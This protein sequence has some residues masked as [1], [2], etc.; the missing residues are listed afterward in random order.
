M[1]TTTAPAK[2]GR[3]SKNL[4]DLSVTH[5]DVVIIGSGYGGSIAASRL[6]AVG[7]SVCLL[8]RGR[9]IL[10]G[11]YPADISGAQKEIELITARKGHLKPD[12]NGMMQLRV[13][14]DVNVVLGNGL[15]GGSLVNAGVSIEPDPR[16]FLEGWP[17][18]YQPDAPLGEATPHPFRLADYYTRVRTNLGATKLP[19]KITL[20]KL[21]ALEKSAKEMKQNFER[22][23]INVTFEDGPNHFGFEQKACNM[24]G[25]C[26]SGCNYEAKNTLL[27]NYLPDAARSGAVLVTEAE[28]HTV[29]PDGSNWTISTLDRSKPVA[30][31]DPIALSAGM[32]VLAAGSL[33]STEILSRSVA[34]NK[35]FAVSSALGSKFSM[36]GDVLAFGFGANLPGSNGSKDAATPLYSIG[37][38]KHPPNEPKYQSGPCITGVVRVDME[39]SK[40][41]KHGL[42]IEDGTAPGLFASAY[43]PMMFLQEVLGGNCF[44]YPDTAARLQGLADLGEGIQFGGDPA[45][46]SYEG[47]MAQMQCYLIMSHDTAHG[48]LV[49]SPETE[50]V[51]VDWPKA[52]YAPVYQRD[53]DA[54]E[55]ASRAIWANLIPNPIWEEGFGRKLVSVHPLG[56]CPMADSDAE[57]VTDPDC[58][59]YKGDGQ[60]SVYENFLICDGSVSPTSLGVNPLLTI[61]AITER[62]MDKL[63]GTPK[64]VSERAKP[65]PFPPP[66]TPAPTN[67]YAKGVANTGWNVDKIIS[68]LDKTR[69]AI[70]AIWVSAVGNLGFEKRI[71]R[72]EIEQLFERILPGADLTDFIHDFVEACDLPKDLKP[73]LDYLTDQLHKLSDALS[74]NQEHPV[75]PFLKALFEVAGDI[76]PGLSFDEAMRGYLS[77]KWDPQGYGVSNPYEIAEASGKAMGQ[78]LVGEFTITAKQTLGHDRAGDITGQLVGADLDGRVLLNGAADK[79]TVFHVVDGRFDLLL[80]DPDRVETWLMTYKCK[81]QA[82]GAQAATWNMVGTKVLRRDPGSFWWKDL[83]TLYVDLTPIDPAQA[84]TPKQGIIRLDLQDLAAQLGTVTA[85]FDCDLT[86]D[87]LKNDLLSAAKNGTLAKEITDGSILHKAFK[88]LLSSHRADKPDTWPHSLAFAL[89]EFFAVGI[90]GTFGNLILRTY[91][92][93]ISYMQDFPSESDGTLKA[94]PEPGVDKVHG[95]LCEDITLDNPTNGKIR[96]FHFAP[97]D[98]DTA[99]GP[100]LLAPGMS[101]T[102]LSFALKTIDTSL[103]ERLLA[104]NYDVWLFDSRLSPTVTPVE[105]GYTLDDVASQDWPTAVDYVLANTKVK[106]PGRATV[107]ILGHCVGA[108]T[109]Q[110][111]L[112]GGHVDTAKVRQMIVMQ[113]TVHPAASAFDVIKSE[114]GLAKD[115]SGGFPPVLASAVHS[116]MGDGAE[117]D[118]VKKVLE[119][120]LPTIDPVS[121][122]P[123]SDAYQKPLDEIHNTVDWS[124]PF[125]IDHVCYSPTCHRIYGL[126]GPVIAHKNLNE[127]T[128]NAM[129]QMFG[130]IATKP[131]VQLGLIMELGRAVSAEGEDIYLPNYERLDMPFHVISGSLN[132]IVQPE[133]GFRTIQ[134]L[135]NA[136]PEKAHQFTRTLVKGYAHNDCFIGKESNKDVFDGIMNVLR[137]FG[138]D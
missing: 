67:T 7:K 133:S 4:S 74:D 117:W 73:G 31:Q 47:I 42:L 109:A 92:G 107:Q 134:W 78:S 85:K 36:N 100:I 68:G 14:D 80:P 52:G 125:G 118:A 39:M 64:P 71:V 1:T 51:S 49:Y 26:C 50:L 114:V 41:L 99:K 30:G 54:L 87:Q 44:E 66:S 61:S 131:F 40:P 48:K 105:S 25:D 20:P 2:I 32:V 9:E 19:E 75:Q 135:K 55:E 17:K 16:V 89:E 53:N 102:A 116:M 106:G 108:L 59:L 113:F 95:S 46:L 103:V 115:F 132:Q 84:E 127:A 65:T 28:V 88:V 57:G 110:M 96:L 129:R 24:C 33:G 112:L 35:D 5:F 34:A 94:L 90:G 72:W 124:A 98:P 128:H 138:G 137:P 27:M 126:Y 18:A 86:D 136:M 69:Y 38:G 79:E 81:L 60:N 122:N 97:S 23:D 13:N 130:E 63:V 91:G 119:D 62:A 21:T 123:R 101:T 8:E 121:P 43:P 120:G 93:F 10:P 22:A 82:E 58:R 77:D 3:I 70:D 83:T 56:G 111:A 6:A 15:G 104:E 12:V 29:S 45:H 37:A 11:Q 76:S